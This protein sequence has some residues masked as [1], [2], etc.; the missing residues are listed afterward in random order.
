[1]ISAQF[2]REETALVQR[3]NDTLCDDHTDFN[4]IPPSVVYK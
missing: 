2:N 4:T 3:S 1:M